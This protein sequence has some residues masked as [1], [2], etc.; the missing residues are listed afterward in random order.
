MTRIRRDRVAGRTLAE[1]IFG[2]I[3][4]SAV[5]ALIGGI[6]LPGRWFFL[7][8]IL[9]GAVAA[10]LLVINMYDTIEASLEMNEKRAKSYA[11]R[12]GVLRILITG[13]LLALAI[14]IDIYAFVGVALGVASLKVSGL[15]HIPIAAL[16]RRFVPEEPDPED[17]GIRYTVGSVGSEDDKEE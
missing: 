2:I 8:G 15:L 10:C 14:W 6:F 5:L 4:V 17:T 11:A 9:V 16:F 1:L 13:V 3:L 7:G 12:H